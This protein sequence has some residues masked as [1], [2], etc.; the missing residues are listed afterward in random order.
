M[1]TWTVSPL[2]GYVEPDFTVPLKATLVTVDWTVW[3]RVRLLKLGTKRVTTVMI[4]LPE[5]TEMV[6]R[7]LAAKPLPV[8]VT[9]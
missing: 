3:L 4:T 2:A 7:E 5:L 1:V 8:T 6:A 9:A